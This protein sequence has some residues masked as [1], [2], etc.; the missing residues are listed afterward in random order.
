MP[1]THHPHTDHPGHRTAQVLSVNTGGPRTGAWTG[2]VGRS[3]IDKS[4]A[5][6]AVA[7]RFDGL[8]GD[9]VCDRKYHSGPDHAVYAF[10]REDLDR[11]GEE[12]GQHLPDGFFGENLTTLGI[13]VNEAVIGER[14]RVGTALL[15]VAK[16]R[17]P[18]RVF[19][20]WLGV[21]GLPE[22]GWIKRF[23]AEGR[24]GPYL[25]VLEEGVV[26]AGDP[27]VVEHRPD[28]GITVAT[29]FRAVTTRRSLLPSL[30]DAPELA[31]DVRA[32][33]LKERERRAALTAGRP[34]AAGAV[35]P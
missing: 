8:V 6:A 24:P 14:W 34:G 9:H 12:L 4:P 16:V 10:A 21:N 20:G 18:C 30:L 5:G 26:E 15:E 11:W 35:L 33:A 17:T 28:H 29:V 22:E 19:A 13:D 27:L 31:A 2:R 7:V 32:K 3:A 1:H 23:A 25:R